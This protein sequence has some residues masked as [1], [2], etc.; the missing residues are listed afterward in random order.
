MIRCRRIV[1]WWSALLVMISSLPALAV[2]TQMT[3]TGYLTKGG[4]PVTATVPTV[5][6]KL[7]PQATGGIVSEWE[8]SFKNVSVTDGVF[9]LVLGKVKPLGAH[10][11]KGVLP[12]YAEVV[13]GGQTMTP[14]LPLVS[15]PHAFTAQNCTGHLTPKSVKV[16]GQEVINTSGAWVGPVSTTSEKDP[17]F[18]KSA[19]GGIAPAHVSNWNS[20]AACG[21]G[22]M[23]AGRVPRCN[24]SALV[25][26]SI[27]DDGKNVGI[28][29]TNPGTKL[30]VS[31][32]VTATK[33]YSIQDGSSTLGLDGSAL[34]LYGGGGLKLTV[35]NGSKKVFVDGLVVAKTT[36][37]VGVGTTMP[38]APMHVHDG[39]S[40]GRAIRLTRKGYSDNFD[41]FI[42]SG[43]TGK[44]GLRMKMNNK[45]IMFIQSNGHVGIGKTNPHPAFNL[46]VVGSINTNNEF[47]ISGSSGHNRITNSQGTEWIKWT[48]TGGGGDIIVATANTERM[49]VTNKGNVGI[50]TSKPGSYMLNVAGPTYCSSG[51]WSG[52]DQRW[53]K[54]VAPLERPLDR[55]TRLKGVTFNW[56]THKH[57]DKGFPAGKQ[58]GLIAQEVEK[59]VPEVVM[60]DGEGYK[61]VSY[62]KLT[63]L[64][65]EAIKAQQRTIEQQQK[66]YRTL[67][68]RVSALEAKVH[69]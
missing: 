49:R 2:P 14:R 32:G 15:V 24:G 62:E 7:F 17:V 28:G 27:Y 5:L 41:M 31:G 57:P 61:A 22:T 66:Q 50:G 10:V 21:A 65:I 26:G 53:K 36:G 48:A 69:R 55:V 45:D 59:V 51:Q 47:V 30:Y 13:L 64:L 60:A 39:D 20:A 29:T 18:I 6:V 16:G 33:G 42:S 35:Y 37:H 8:E 46:D 43:L 68:A 9:T 12:K 67:L 34:R 25:A 19:A 56:K 1:L 54:N 11:F 4:K 40:K 3:Y 58:I 23:G 63:P 44:P 38:D 52:S